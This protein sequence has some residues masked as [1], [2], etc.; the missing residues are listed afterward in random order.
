MIMIVYVFHDSYQG[1]NR[2]LPHTTYEF[3]FTIME[4]YFFFKTN[5]IYVFQSSIIFIIF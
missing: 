2:E 4:Q 5:S 3:L 1:F